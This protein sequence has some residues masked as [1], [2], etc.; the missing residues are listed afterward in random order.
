VS[1]AVVTEQIFAWPGMGTLA[2]RAASDRDPASLKG[3]VLVVG[4][5]VLVS[6]LLADIAYAVADPL[7]VSGPASL[8]SKAFFRFTRHRLAVGGSIV[9]LVVVLIAVIAPLV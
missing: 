1:G 5:G 3:V 7:Y 9:M 4:V 8:A 2:V 6:S